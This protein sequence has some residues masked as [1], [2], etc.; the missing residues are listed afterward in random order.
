[1]RIHQSIIKICY[2]KARTFSKPIMAC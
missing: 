1:V 2:K